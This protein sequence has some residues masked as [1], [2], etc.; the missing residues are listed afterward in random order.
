MADTDQYKCE[1]CDYSCHSAEARFNHLSS[2]RH[3]VEFLK[4]YLWQH[5]ETLVRNKRNVTISCL[6][7]EDSVPS[8]C[9]QAQQ[10][11]SVELTLQVEVSSES[12]FDV[13]LQ[14]CIL[15]HPLPIFSLNDPGGVSTADQE[16]VIPVGSCYSIALR[17]LSQELGKYRVPLAFKFREGGTEGRLFTIVRYLEVTCYEDGGDDLEPV[18]PYF[19]V[20]PLPMLDDADR[21]IL[22][23]KVKS[24]TFQE[25]E[26][27][28][29][30][31]FYD[32]PKELMVLQEHNMKHWEGMEEDHAKLLTFIQQHLDQP[33]S[34]S[35]Y[36]G[37]FSTLLFL[38]EIQMFTDIRK[39]DMQAVPLRPCPTQTEWFVLEVPGLVEG[40]PALL[41]GDRLYAR[42]SASDMLEVLEYEGIVR[43]TKTSAVWVSFSKRFLREFVRGMKFDVRFTYNRLPLRLMHRAIAMCEKCKLWDYVL[44]KFDR[45]SE[46]AVKLGRLTCFNKNV[47]DNSEQFTAVKNILLGVHRPYPYLLFGPPGTGKTVTVVEALKQI[48]HIMPSSHILVLAPSNSASDLLAERLLEHIM[49]SQIFRI[50]ATSV[51][52]NKV[53]KKLMKCCNYKPNDRSFFYPAKE[54]LLKYKVLVSTLANSGRLVSAEMPLNHFTHIFVDEAGHSLEPEC[55]IPLVGLMSPWDRSRKGVGGHLVLAGDPLQLGPIVRSKQARS[56]NFGVSLLERLMELPPYQRLENGYYNPQMLTKLLRNFRSHA[57]ILEIPNR[58]FYENELQVFAD[59]RIATCMLQWEGLPHMGVPLLF[60]GVCGRDLRESSNP[61][62]YNPEEVKVVVDYATALLQGKSGLGV[63]IREED[64]GIISPYRKQVLKIRI[65]LEKRGYNGVTV[66]STEEFQGQE[67]LVIIISTVRSNPNLLAN[68]FRHDIGFLRNRKRFNVA[69][70]RAKSLLIIV[71]NPHTLNKDTCWRSLLQFCIRKRAYKGVH[72]GGGM[73]KIDDL[74]QRFAAANIVDEISPEDER[75]FEG[76]IPITQK[77]LQEEPRWREEL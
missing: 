25:L 24:S 16:V 35:T 50:Y 21:I 74:E 30:L 41:K 13:T 38:E 20:P 31:Q 54:K 3:F 67:R 14:A 70:T 6:E 11:R 23:D 65:M 17:C 7:I 71:G 28:V 47:Q 46:P 36:W 5:E 34:E 76:R 56:Y 60:H 52:P 26:L 68:D 59:D 2:K 27:K 4:Y 32:L 33:L 66:G 69:V 37:C 12:S 58:M 22:A 64:V 61:S 15:L 39:Y 53:S 63:R 72:F 62:Y 42:L 29:P 55:L 10:G 40:R 45:P 73:E 57:D 9:F 51:N 43:E 8:I 44:P 18:E 19:Y 48:C 49:P 77:T 1:L 75:V